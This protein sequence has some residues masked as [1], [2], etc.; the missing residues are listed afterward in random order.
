MGVVLPVGPA[1]KPRKTRSTVVVLSGIGVL[2]TVG[3]VMVL[4]AGQR[5]AP[6]VPATL[7]GVN[8]PA[9][10]APVTQILRSVTYELTGDSGANDVTYVGQGASI[11]QV[12]DADAPWSVS[13]DHSGNAGESQFFSL[14]ARNAGKGTLRCRILVDG[15]TV[16]QASATGAGSVVRC[17]KSVS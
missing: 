14:S 16:S 15:T 2:V 6:P 5:S 4:A 17:A 8:V 11:V 7:N 3:V 1:R 12:A 9:A 13:L 10:P